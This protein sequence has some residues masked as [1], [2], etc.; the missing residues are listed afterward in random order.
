MSVVIPVYNEEEVLPE[1]TRRLRAILPTLGMEWDVLFVDDGSVDRSLEIVSSLARKDA[2]FRVV[3]LSRNFGHQIAITAGLDHV[4]S[5]V[6]IIMDADLQDPPEVIADMLA[7]WREGFE[8]VYGK[9]I[10]REGES[11]FKLATAKLFYKLLR[12]LS[13]FDIPVEAGDFRLLDRK[14][15]EAI[16]QVRELH[17]FVRG[18]VSWVGFRQTSVLYQRRSR[19]AGQTKYPFFKM[20][21]F[22]FDAITSFSVQPLRIASFLGLF[23]AFSG[24]VGIFGMLY[25]KVFTDRVVPGMASLFCTILFLGGTQLVFLGVLGEYLGRV[26]QESKN[27]PLY[28]IRETVNAPKKG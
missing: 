9:R 4:D 21:V 11:W 28:F 15:V 18:L 3:A 22:A 19:A 20:L 16:R 27:R 7:K 14:V 2:H 23:V 25:L 8:M 17:R 26:Y 12:R 10:S 5:D 13:N 24:V 6:T 1:L